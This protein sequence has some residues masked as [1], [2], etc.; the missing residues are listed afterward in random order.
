MKVRLTHPYKVVLPTCYICI[1]SYLSRKGVDLTRDFVNY[2]KQTT[3]LLM[4]EGEPYL[5]LAFDH[6][7][8]QLQLLVLFH[9][10]VKLG[11]RTVSEEPAE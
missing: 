11:S 10:K 7:Q 8:S 6:L 2:I 9:F 1:P 5:C 4:S 3:L